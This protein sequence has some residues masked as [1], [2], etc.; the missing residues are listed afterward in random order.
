MLG[1]AVERMGGPG[2]LGTMTLPA[3]VLLRD[4]GSVLVRPATPADAEVHIA[5]THA[6]ASERIYL[7]SESFT[8]T[9]EEIRVQF[10][11]AD[12]QQVLW[13]VA[14]VDGAVVGGANF[15]RGRWRKNAHTAD[16][17][18]ALLPGFRGRGIGEAL[19]REGIEWARSVGVR[20]LTLGVF[21]TNE[22]A[23][24][25]YRRLGFAEEARLRGQ[26]I[27]DGRPVDEILM[28]LWI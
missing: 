15:A 18:V 4:G 1:A 10:R 27:L 14:E 7:M 21:A 28:A 8:R 13:L 11:D 17:G 3:T 2:V 6:I 22:R 5:N 19:M 24:A 25:L 12:P 26:G 9:V 20:K 16:L 23:V